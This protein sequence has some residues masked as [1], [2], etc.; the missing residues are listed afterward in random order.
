ME[1]RILPVT[2]ITYLWLI[3]VVTW[4]AAAAWSDRAVKR[5][6]SMRQAPYNIITAI[7]AILLFGFYPQ[8]PYHLVVW[9]IGGGTAWCMVVL[10]TVG[11]SFS[12]WAR[13]HL[14]R[15]WSRW[16]VRKANHYIIQTGPYAFVRHP[17]YT[18][19]ILATLATAV[20]FGTAFAYLGA[21]FVILSFYIKARL[22]ERF[23]REELSA[24]AYDAYA[25]RVAML[26]PFLRL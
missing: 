5:A 1:N 16:V 25:Q 2:A 12:W 17:I 24:E 15:L 18:G 9:R 14:G 21:A 11:F 13:V 26:L 20:M 10:A 7:G 22:E 4:W 8:R 3:W 6:G 19:I 23:L